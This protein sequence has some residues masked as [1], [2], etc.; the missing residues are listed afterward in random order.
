MSILSNVGGKKGSCYPTHLSSNIT[1]RHTG[2]TRWFPMR[3]I[4]SLLPLHFTLY[5]TLKTIENGI[6]SPSKSLDVI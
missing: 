5:S 1:S 6:Q 4:Y 3:P 2:G